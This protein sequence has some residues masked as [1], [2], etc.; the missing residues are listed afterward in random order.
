MNVRPVS[1]IRPCEKAHLFQEA[2]RDLD[3]FSIRVVQPVDVEPIEIAEHTVHPFTLLELL[4]HW[5]RLTAR[6]RG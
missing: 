6:R 4:L 1:G 2:S 3:S 5:K